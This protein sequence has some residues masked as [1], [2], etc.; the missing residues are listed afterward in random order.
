MKALKSL[1]VKDSNSPKTIDEKKMRKSTK[2]VKKKPK[3][4]F[5]R[6]NQLG[7]N[8][9]LQDMEIDPPII[10]Y[11]ASAPQPVPN[12]QNFM[13][14]FFNMFQFWCNQTNYSQMN[15]MN[16]LLSTPNNYTN[17]NKRPK[18]KFK[19]IINKNV[20]KKKFFKPNI[21]T[22][23]AQPVVVQEAT[24]DEVPLFTFNDVD[25]RFLDTTTTSLDIDYRQLTQLEL[26]NS[27]EKSE[28]KQI[29]EAKSDDEEQSD[30]EAEMMN[31]RKTLLDTLNQK[32]SLKKQQEQEQIDQDIFLLKKKLVEHEKALLEADQKETS[33]TKTNAIV[34]QKAKID[35]IIIRIG[36]SESSDEENEEKNLKKNIGQFLNEA[37]E[38]A[39]ESSLK[40]KV[41]DSDFS[42]GELKKEEEKKDVIKS[43]RDRINLKR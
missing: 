15:Q 16:G 20:N 3:K 7:D 18:K 10:Q 28:T 14:N 38:M 33:R 24:K 27:L 8:Y 4:I 29:E 6:P 32:R 36:L 41:V 26:L 39:I 2:K 23:S 11:Q 17:F 19:K 35:P 31:L 13:Q 37:K 5:N 40:R 1:L 42:E 30:N 43:L 25:E 9:E 21:N 34:R 22:Q 12:Y